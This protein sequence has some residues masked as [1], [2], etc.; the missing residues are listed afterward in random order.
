MYTINIYD[1]LE[2][3]YT[4][5]VN[6][7][8]TTNLP[9]NTR[10]W[11]VKNKNWTI[12]VKKELNDSYTAEVFLNN[13]LN[14][15]SIDDLTFRIFDKNDRVIYM[16]SIYS[17]IEKNEIIRIIKEMASEAIDKINGA[18]FQVM[19]IDDNFKINNKTVCCPFFN[20]KTGEYIETEKPEPITLKM[21]L[22]M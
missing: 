16:N 22:D 15:F 10:W 2:D 19:C 17:V 9:N 11:K 3:K 21:D 13:S 1:A 8:I 4:Q 14:S 7:P 6:I 20:L 12:S 18:E 5:T